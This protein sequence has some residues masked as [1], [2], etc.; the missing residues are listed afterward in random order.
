MH[1]V[2]VMQKKDIAAAWALRLS[3]PQALCV[4]PVLRLFT[5]LRAS[6]SSLVPAL[7][8]SVSS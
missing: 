2:H 7:Y 4:S 5:S 3:S 1:A 8:F 6:G